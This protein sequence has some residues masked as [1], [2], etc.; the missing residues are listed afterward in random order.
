[1]TKSPDSFC[2]QLV[3]YKNLGDLWFGANAIRPYISSKLQMGASMR[4]YTKIV[5]P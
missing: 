2:W 4:P 5:H 3:A 1:V